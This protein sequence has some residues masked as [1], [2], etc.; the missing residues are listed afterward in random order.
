MVNSSLS[1]GYFPAVWKEALVNR[2]L[3]KAGLDPV[4]KNL[5]PVSNLHFLSK[6]TERAGF[7]QT[8]DHMMDL[9]LYPMLES[10][11]KKCHSTETALLKVQ[12]DILMNMNRQYVSVLIL[13]HLSAA[14]DTADHKIL[15]HRLHSSLGITGRAL[16]RLELNLSHRSQRL[17][18]G[19]C[20]K[21]LYGVPQGSCLG[22]LL[23]TIYSSKLCEVIKDQLPAAQ[24]YADGLYL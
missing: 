24:A 10:A 20:L 22:P 9:S 21:L 3:K 8:C 7:D 15:L 12:N 19:G 5:R 17:F 13:P 14:F 4:F 16:K 1:S 18:S 11:Y 23:F 2:I 6:L